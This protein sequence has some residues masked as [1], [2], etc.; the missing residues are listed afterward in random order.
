MFRAFLHR[1]LERMMDAAEVFKS[2]V[3]YVGKDKRR[4]HVLSKLVAELDGLQLKCDFSILCD[5]HTKAVAELK[6]YYMTGLMSYDEYCARAAGAACM[7]EI[8]QK[9]QTSMTMRTLEALFFNKKL[10]TTNAAA[11]L[12]PFYHPDNIYVLDGNERRTIRDF[13]YAGPCHYPRHLIADYDIE[14]WICRF[15]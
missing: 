10:V 5:K 4:S 1:E 14:H 2:D 9:G 13:I 6:P 7:L 15:L 11:R 8:L 3:F 12:L